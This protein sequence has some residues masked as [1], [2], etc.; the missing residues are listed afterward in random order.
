M[1][2]IT[3]KGFCS[4]LS[5]FEETSD[6]S[7]TVTPLG[8]GSRWGRHPSSPRSSRGWGSL[9]AFLDW[10]FNSCSRKCHVK[11]IKILSK[12]Q[13]CKRKIG[14]S[15]NLCETHGK[16]PTYN[17]PE[18]NQNLTSYPPKPF[19]FPK[20]VGFVL[21]K[22][23]RTERYGALGVGIIPDSM[24]TIRYLEARLYVRKS[25]SGVRVFFN[26]SS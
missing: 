6:A 10:D 20:L 3:P 12:I 5:V 24:A 23:K 22:S 15:R 8:P 11:I 16:A 17:R 19:S 21:P 14:R 1:N 9:A 18:L 2:S 13:D 26:E 4:F 7:K 25:R